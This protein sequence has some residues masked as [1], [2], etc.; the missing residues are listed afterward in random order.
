MSEILL[1]KPKIALRIFC[2]FCMF[3]KNR[4]RKFST[5]Y[6]LKY[7]LNQ[8]EGEFHTK[9]LTLEHVRKTLCAVEKA[10]HIGMVRI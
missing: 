5:I 10:I 6:A 1:I 9:D 2:P 4:S 3:H 8:H 7:H